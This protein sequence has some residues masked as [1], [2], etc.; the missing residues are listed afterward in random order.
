MMIGEN[1]AKPTP[2]TLKEHIVK[3][4]NK[5]GLTLNKGDGDLAILFRQPNYGIVQ[6]V[7]IPKNTLVLGIT[8]AVV[9]LGQSSNILKEKWDRL[10]RLLEMVEGSVN[11]VD[12]RVCI[13][14]DALVADKLLTADERNAIGKRQ[15]TY[16]E[17]QFGAGITISSD[18]I[19]EA[20][21]S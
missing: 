7:E 8:T 10:M 11:I 9:K 5:I 6:D 19:A 17:V 16:S 12:P 1:M 4:P 18:D 3:D 14:L 2:Q 20:R 21:R 13:L 15:G